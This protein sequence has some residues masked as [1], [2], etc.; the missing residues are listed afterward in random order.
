MSDLNKTS[1]GPRRGAT[2][3]ECAFALPITLI[4]LFGMLDLGLA[5]ARYNAISDAAR[6]VARAA[7]IHGSLESNRSAS[8][9]PLEYVGTAADNSPIAITANSVLPAMQKDQVNVHVTWPD[10]NNSPGDRVQVEISYLH[11]PLL[12][13]LFAW[14]P[15]TLRAVS[16]MRIVN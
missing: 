1:L 12:P 11:K 15:L 4:L 3:I 13:K 10:N 6:R 7:I 9:G 14:G 2:M 5:A 16:T 8:W